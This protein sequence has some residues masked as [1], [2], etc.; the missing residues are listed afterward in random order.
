M[1]H[2]RDI[3]WRSQPVPHARPVTDVDE[4][5]AEQWVEPQARRL[6]IASDNRAVIGKAEVRR[7]KRVASFHLPVVCW[8]AH[9][10][11]PQEAG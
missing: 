7:R 8:G 2:R 3:A 5:A 4:D 1:Q 11:L 9:I 6:A 10:R